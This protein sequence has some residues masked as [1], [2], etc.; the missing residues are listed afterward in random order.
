[1]TVS[2]FSNLAPVAIPDL[3]RPS[4]IAVIA[5]TR[6]LVRGAE[7]RVIDELT[8]RVKQESVA[9]DLSRVERIDAAGIAALITLYCTAIEAG[10]EFY[11]VSPS[12]RV[13]DMLRLV[14][15]ESILVPAGEPGEAGEPN[16]EQLS[17]ERS[18]A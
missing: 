6:E 13:L 4:A 10:H 11:V 3:N 1:M 5:V 17:F 14:G 18:A 7:D 16:Q 8:P 15:L 12:A 2:P 9:L